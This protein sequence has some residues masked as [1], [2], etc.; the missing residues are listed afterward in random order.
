[1]KLKKEYLYAIGGVIVLI[2]SFQL[3]KSL[4][5]SFI[6]LA[7]IFGG[8]YLAYNLKKKNPN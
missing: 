3:A 5:T 8:G 6:T 7:I 2:T 1:M 4:I